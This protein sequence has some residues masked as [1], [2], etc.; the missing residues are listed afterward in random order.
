MDFD[1]KYWSEGEFETKSGEP[2]SGYVGISG[3][4]GYI[5]DTEE[6]LVKSDSYRTQ[7]NSSEFFFD[8]ILDEEIKLPYQKNDVRFAANDFL[9]S[10]VL[11]NIITKL[12]KNNDYIFRNAIIS[13]TLV[14]NTQ[15]C[16]ILATKE[17]DYYTFLG[18]SGKEYDVAT[19]ANLDD[20]KNGF[21]VNGNS[22]SITRG[23]SY[24]LQ[25]GE[26]PMALY[27]DYY[28]VPATVK[29]SNL[30]NGTLKLYN[31]T[32]K[33]STKTALD[34]T[35]YPQVDAVTGV[36]T[37]P[38]FNFNDITHSEI[39]I[40]KIEDINGTK[41]VN[42]LI[43]LL[44]KTKVVIFQYPLFIKDNKV[45]QGEYPEINFSSDSKDLL[46]LERTDPFNKN[47]LAFL[48]LKD[49][50]I[51][52]NYM[53]LV[54]ET[55]N[56]VLRYDIDYLLN[57]DSDMW[58]NT[59]SIRLLDILQGDGNVNDEIYFN[60]PVSVAVDDDFIYV[61]D[62]GNGCVK[63]Y[64]SSFD[65]IATLRNGKFAEHEIGAIAINPYSMTMDNGEKLSPGT[66]WVFSTSGSH[67]WITIIDK[68]SISYSKQIEKIEL[69][70]DKFTWD[71]DFKSVKF[72]FSDS[73]YFYISTT[74]RVYK[75]HLSKP[76]YPF[77]SLSYYKQRSLLSSMVWSSVPY[78][79]HTLPD[80]T[81][82]ENVIITWGYRP[83]KTSA[84]VLDNRA[85]CLCG[86]DSTSLIE[87]SKLQEQFNGDIIFHIG[88][89]YDQYLVDTYIIRNNVTFDQIPTEELAKMVKC[90]GLFLYLEQPTFI[91]SVSNWSIPCYTTEDI[92]RIPDDEYVNPITFNAHIYKLVYNLVNMKN[93]LIGTFQGA[94]NMDNIMVYDQIIL[95]DFFQQLRIENN[96]DLLIHDNELASIIVNRIFEKIFDL[97]D[98]I[99]SHMKAKYIS[100]PSFNNNTFRTI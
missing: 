67:M 14:P 58:Y 3:G 32:E 66:L 9:S 92:Q 31:L 69:L 65:Y 77:A 62:R 7:V 71:E 91:S 10:S 87:N 100:T 23:D 49:I 24:P 33:K 18:N 30:Q 27:G 28:K 16:F 96:D 64:S 12:Q 53:Y 42:L 99:L 41:K 21:V 56:M 93:I 51:H 61:A 11:K 13:N 34:S 4:D 36:K 5:Y 8:R 57:D 44:F 47:S 25:E 15:E 38:L 29:H 79:W 85:F 54:D 50:E 98:T 95:D 46:V 1:K 55:L 26:R 82:D 78:P 84:E 76:T 35:F 22:D 20:I 94:Y 81:E 37:E 60:S 83:Q 89:L 6:K 63:K 17:N 73:N 97:Q 72:S 75:L 40:K 39:I 2:Y 80:G 19:G 45:A 74:K 48:G 59:R 52:R 88:N 68:T 43:F 90:S 70:Q 86:N